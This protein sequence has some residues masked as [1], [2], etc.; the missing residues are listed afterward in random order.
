MVRETGLFLAA[1]SAASVSSTLTCHWHVIHTLAIQVQ[2]S[3][4]WNRKTTILWMIV[5]YW[6][7][8]Q[9]LNLHEIA[10]TRT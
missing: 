2:I 4:L 7:G 6:C 1:R 3:L 10:F 5:F 8:K 9:D